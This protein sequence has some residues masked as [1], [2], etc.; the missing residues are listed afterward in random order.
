MD[1]GL[2]TEDGDQQPG[3]AVFGESQQLCVQA[4]EVLCV[5]LEGVSCTPW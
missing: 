1:E 3:W 2:G 5:S 4:Q